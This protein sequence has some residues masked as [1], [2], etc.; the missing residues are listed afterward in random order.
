MRSA[1]PRP[2]SRRSL[3]ASPR[4][5]RHSSVSESS[6]SPS[7]SSSSSSKSSSSSSSSSCITVSTGTDFS[8]TSGRDSMWRWYAFSSSSPLRW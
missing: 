6:S 7:P 3:R 2:A 1:A 5:W 4:S 8:A